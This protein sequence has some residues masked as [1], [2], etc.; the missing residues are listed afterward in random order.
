[1]NVADALAGPARAAL[2]QNHHEQAERLAQRA[3]TLSPSLPHAGHRVIAQ[4]SLR[5]SHDLNDREHL[6]MRLTGASR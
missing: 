3:R 1:M 4:A 5:T 2:S 6:L